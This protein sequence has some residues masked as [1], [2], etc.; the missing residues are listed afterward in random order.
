MIL[1]GAAIPMKAFEPGS[2]ASKRTTALMTEDRQEDLKLGR[3]LS[4]ARCLRATK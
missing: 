2:D 3:G 4:R 1:P